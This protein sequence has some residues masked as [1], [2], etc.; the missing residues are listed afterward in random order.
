MSWWWILWALV[1]WFGETALHEL[2]HLVVGVAQG[3]KLEGLGFIPWPHWTAK[4]R[5]F[6]GRVDWDEERAPG[7]ISAVC[8][9]APYLLICLTMPTFLV[10]YHLTGWIPWLF[11]ATAAWGD[12]TRGLLQ[13]WLFRRGDVARAGQSLIG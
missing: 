8:H 12:L 10:L 4:G 3:Q 9:L 11:F 2:A 5:F 6:F 7:P 13:P 1:A